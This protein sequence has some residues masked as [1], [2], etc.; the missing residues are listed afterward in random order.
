MTTLSLS[1][2]GTH[3]IGPNLLI[4]PDEHLIG[5]LEKRTFFGVL[6]VYVHMY[7]IFG[8]SLL[9]LVTRVPEFQ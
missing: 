2:F 5:R 4:A 6:V 7:K 1:Q 3:Q 8:P 9:L